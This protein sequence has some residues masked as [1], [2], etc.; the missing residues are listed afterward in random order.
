MIGRIFMGRYEVLR[1]IGEGGMGRVYLARSLDNNRQ[2]V[3]KVMHEHIAED[4][5]FRDRFARESELMKGFR[6]PYC[7]SFL[8]ASLEDPLGPCLVMEYIRGKN[9]DKLLEKNTRFNPARVGRLIGQLCDVLHAAH[10]SGMIHR[11]LKP[12]NLMVIEPDTPNETIK[13]MDFGLA[14]MVERDEMKKVTDTNVDFAVGTPGYICPEQVRGEEMDHRGDIYSVGVIMYE[15]LTGRLPFLGPSSMDM[16]L[17]HATEVPPSFGELNMGIYIPP[18]VEQVVFTCLAKNREDRPQSARVLAEWFEGALLSDMEPQEEYYE[19][20]SRV[21]QP[22]LM[23]PELTRDPSVLTYHMEAWMPQSI[24]IVKVRGFVHDSG[25][26]V[27][28]SVPGLIRVRMG[29]RG[30]TRGSALS[31][32]GLGRK[33]TAIELELRLHSVEARGDSK[34]LIELIFRPNSVA[35]LNDET[36]RERCATIFIEA[37]AYLMGG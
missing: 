4:Q 37:R 22:E 12:S 25:G 6:H 9:L 8:D 34:L 26:E 28:E 24:A 35:Q 30:R 19:E 3:V 7:V 14:K 10:E 1:L 15:L 21:T 18:L 31:W 33:S 16:L 5:K 20:P 23:M 36:W 27:L 29:Q 17:A 13:V 11:D 32:L 2:V